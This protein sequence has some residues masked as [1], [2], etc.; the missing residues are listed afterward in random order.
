MQSPKLMS[1]LQKKNCHQQESKQEIN[2]ILHLASNTAKFQA[3]ISY[4]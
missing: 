2:L 1:Y 4:L 3:G